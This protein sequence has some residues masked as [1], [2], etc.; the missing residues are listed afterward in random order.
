MFY[1]C[2]SMSSYCVL[3][4]KDFQAAGC[5]EENHVIPSSIWR[6]ISN[7]NSQKCQCYVCDNI[8]IHS[9]W[10]ED[11]LP[12]VSRNKTKSKIL[13]V[14]PCFAGCYFKLRNKQ[15][16]KLLLSPAC[17][18]W[19]AEDPASVV[20]SSSQVALLTPWFPTGAG[21]LFRLATLK[22]HSRTGKLS[23]VSTVCIHLSQPAQHSPY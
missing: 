14:Q 17:L 4:T 23:Q 7:P 9:T 20:S 21:I 3:H 22:R 12:E 18:L 13:T 15:H 19:T 6:H 8:C 10:N 1:S 5:L 16:Q 11:V 2:R